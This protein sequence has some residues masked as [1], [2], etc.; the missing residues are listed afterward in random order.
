METADPSG[1]FSSGEGRSFRLGRPRDDS[2]LLS[3]EKRTREGCGVCSSRCIP[4]PHSVLICAAG[5]R[6]APA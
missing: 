3:W 6:G 4:P 5:S 2:L 1:V